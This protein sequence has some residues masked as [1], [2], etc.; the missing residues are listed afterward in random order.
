LS[1]ARLNANVVRTVKSYTRFALGIGI[2]LLGIGWIR[3]IQH[4]EHRSTAIQHGRPVTAV[5]D[6]RRFS[7]PCLHFTCDQTIYTIRYIAAGRIW[8]SAV[9]V[10]GWEHVHP[11]GSRLSVVY[12]PAHPGRVEA[13]GRAPSGVAPTIGAWLCIVFGT[14]LTLAW[15]YVIRRDIRNRRVSAGGP[16][17]DLD[18]F[19][20]G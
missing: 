19:P 16:V 5:I 11:P 15:G 2:L 12:D 20:G 10:D 8:R 17:G 7:N 1:G 3:S 6:E 13:G 4:A 14:L 9:I 18:S